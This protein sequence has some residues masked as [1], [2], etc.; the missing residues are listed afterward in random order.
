MLKEHALQWVSYLNGR[1][2]G[3][4]ALMVATYLAGIVGLILPVSRTLFQSLTPVNLLLSAGIL[5]SFHRQWNS[6]FILFAVVC[7]LLGF[8]SEV[9]G[10]ATGLLFGSYTYGPV[11]GFQLWEVPLI[12]GLNWLMLIYSTGT[13]CANLPLSKFLKAL[14]AS[15]LMVLLDFFIEPVA[16]ALNFWQWEN[17]QIPVQNFIAW[18]VISFILHLLF[19]LLPFPKGNPAA[20][21]LYLCQLVFFI[22]LCLFTVY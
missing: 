7:Y 17:E 21:I 8:F 1:Q 15:G 14:F 2:K 16:M 9:V 18:F 13:I 4:L 11:L 5:F 22:I 19:F 3:L 20:K 6:A 12:I 10:V